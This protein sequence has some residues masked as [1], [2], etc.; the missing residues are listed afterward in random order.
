MMSLLAM[1]TV[2]DGESVVLEHEG[3][4]IDWKRN[5]LCNQ[6]IKNQATHVLFVDPDMKFPSTCAN[7]LLQLDK[8]VV[9]VWAHRKTIPLVPAVVV[10]EEDRRRGAE[11]SERPAEPFN[12][13]GGNPILVGTGIMLIDLLKIKGLSWPWFK[14]EEQWT[15][16]GERVS[17]AGEDLFFCQKVLEAGYEVWCDPT[18]PVK[19]IGDFDY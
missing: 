18:I 4:F 10:Q 5:W 9:G 8:P 6:A 7:Q 1:L 11:D 15:P 2:I 3:H 16:I 19:H 12:R 13:L 17:C 14:A